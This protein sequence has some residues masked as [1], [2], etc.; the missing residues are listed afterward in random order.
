MFMLNFVLKKKNKNWQVEI[1]SCNR[2]EVTRSL[3]GKVVE[4][5]VGGPRFNSQ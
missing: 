5:R 2:I 3:L 4:Q 1:E